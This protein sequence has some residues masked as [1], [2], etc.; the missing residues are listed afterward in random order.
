VDGQKMVIRS[1]A[2]GGIKNH[3]DITFDMTRHETT[4]STTCCQGTKVS[5]APSDSDKVVFKALPAVPNGH[6]RIVEPREIM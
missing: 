6:L 3:K 5:K 4:I 1:S 2:T